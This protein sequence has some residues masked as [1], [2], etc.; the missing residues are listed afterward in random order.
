MLNILEKV[1]T[2]ITKLKHSFD[3]KKETLH[4]NLDIVLIEYEG[5][6]NLSSVSSDLD[7]IASLKEVL[8]GF[9][10][11]EQDSEFMN[12]LTNDELDRLE[13]IFQ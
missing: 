2:I 12:D 5:A 9:S 7:N 1:R 6:V 3:V 13:E 10:I 11:P 8:N 4:E